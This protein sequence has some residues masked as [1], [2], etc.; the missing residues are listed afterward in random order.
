MSV[1]GEMGRSRGARS[2]TCRAGRGVARGRACTT[3]EC[4]VAVAARR[5][6]IYPATT[7]PPKPS[8]L[9]GDCTRGGNGQWSTPNTRKARLGMST[10]T[11]GCAGVL[12]LVA[13]SMPSLV[14]RS[15]L[16]SPEGAPEVSKSTREREMDGDGELVAW[17]QPRVCVPSLCLP[18]LGRDTL[19][20]RR[21]P[22]KVPSS[23][24]PCRVPLLRPR[25]VASQSYES[26][27]AACACS[28]WQAQNP[29]PGGTVCK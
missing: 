29:I 20:P 15:A 2:E 1:V 17:E 22:E 6:F 10:K 14:L 7:L 18:N 9:L 13:P 3:S 5:P 4:R 25:E 12:I 26:T 23:M 27:L 8:S 21:Q 19:V 11:L 24:S 28:V 16:P